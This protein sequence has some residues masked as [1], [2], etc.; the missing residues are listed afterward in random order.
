MEQRPSW[1]AD[2]HSAAQEIPLPFMEPE[3]L[4]PCSQDNSTLSYTKPDKSTLPT[5]FP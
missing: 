2:S 5:L 1:E 3:D 4:L